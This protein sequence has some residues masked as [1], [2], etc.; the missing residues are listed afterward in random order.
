MV[1]GETTGLGEKTVMEG[2]TASSDSGTAGGA[3]EIGEPMTTIAGEAT[4]GGA[5]SAAG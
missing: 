1:A 2:I 5:V 4:L 3:T